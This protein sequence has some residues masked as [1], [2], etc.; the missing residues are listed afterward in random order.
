MDRTI[1]HV[2]CNK[3]YA[4]VECAFRPSLKNV[5]VVV[6]GDEELRHG[7][8]LTKNEIAEKYGIKT[9]EPLVGARRKCKD[10]VVLKPNFPLYKEVSRQVRE[11][12]LRYTDMVEPFGLDEAWLDVTGS[13]HLF[14]D[15]VA[16]AESIRTAVKNELGI[17]VSIGVSFNKVFAKLGSDYKKPDAVTVFSREN[18][19]EL[20]WP[21][22]A[23]DMLFVGKSTVK[24]LESYGIYTI[25]DI[26]RSD[27]EFIKSKFGKQGEV[28]LR[29]ARGEDERPVKNADDKEEY[30]SVG[31]SMTTPR[32]M[33]CYEDVCVVMSY[34]AD[35]VASRLR[36]HSLKGKTVCIS[37]RDNKLVSFTRQGK[38]S[39]YSCIS[40]EILDKALE[41]FRENYSWA[42]P[43]RSVGISVTDF[44]Q[45][46]EAEQMD[47][48]SVSDEKREKKEKLEETIDSLRMRF[49]KN[50]IC[51][52]RSA[53]DNTLILKKSENHSKFYKTNFHSKS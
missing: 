9:G 49:G 31:N 22:K 39:N 10:L 48:F 34:L 13:Y 18:Y 35:T 26:A 15:G 32:D 7:V 8:V 41:L 5:P 11:I 14:G 38:L 42:S 17:T 4:S 37:V 1:L 46:D 12:F 27:D 3:F 50:C 44:P 36:K 45:D 29:F 2:D 47:F 33:T 23:G 43:I 28:L 53:S 40:D 52:A 30:K 19:K 25:G 51:K 21:I 24:K 6:G 20:V 16:I